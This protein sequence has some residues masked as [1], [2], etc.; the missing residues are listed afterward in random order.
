MR[1][2]IGL[3][4]AVSLLAVPAVAHGHSISKRDMERAVRSHVRAIA[5]SIPALSPS[6]VAKVTSVRSTCR[7]GRSSRGHRHA[8]KCRVSVRVRDRDGAT[9]VATRMCRD[10]S[11]RLAV[12]RSG[13]LAV[14][15]RTA[16]LTCRLSGAQPTLPLGSTSPPP[17]APADPT[18]AAPTPD[19]LP[20]PAGLPPGARPPGAPP[21]VT[22]TAQTARARA[23]SSGSTAPRARTAQVWPRPSS[24]FH[25]CS[26]HQLSG[27]WIYDCYWSVGSSAPPGAHL[28]GWKTVYYYE[29]WYW[30]YDNAGNIGVLPWYYGY[31]EY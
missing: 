7:R 15:R 11:V 2:T 1:R 9:H 30:G 28:I 23:A 25:S 27:W 18:P 6:A 5:P 22:A 31:H 14:V 21:G 24:G 16:R 19:T 26:W 8:A 4:M 12:R 17:S 10:A 20:S 29:R 3:V 13:R